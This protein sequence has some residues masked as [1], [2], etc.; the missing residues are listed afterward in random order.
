MMKKET[1]IQMI[2]TTL[3]ELVCAIHEAAQEAEIDERNISEFTKTMV[4]R[5]LGD[6]FI[7][8]AIDPEIV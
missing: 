8:D 5:L 7:F 2:D 3:G 6:R 1:D 4:I